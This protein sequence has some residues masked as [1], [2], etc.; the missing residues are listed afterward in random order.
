MYVG[1]MVEDSEWVGEVEVGQFHSQIL[2]RQE[3]G[4]LPFY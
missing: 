4:T 1:R 3:R 2:R